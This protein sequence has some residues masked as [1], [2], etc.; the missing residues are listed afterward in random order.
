MKEC[1]IVGKEVTKKLDM[2]EKV[3]EALKET[4]G[5]VDNDLGILLPTRISDSLED[6]EVKAEKPSLDKLLAATNIL[7]STYMI[8]LIRPITQDMHTY[9]QPIEKPH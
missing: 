8:C 7:K 1:I 6:S 3:M 5:T 4:G 2:N 9:G